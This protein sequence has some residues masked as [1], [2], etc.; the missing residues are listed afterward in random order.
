MLNNKLRE[1]F[2]KN[3]YF[4]IK[5]FP[6]KITDQF[7][8]E[9]AKSIKLIFEREFKKNT[10]FKLN[11]KDWLINQGMAYLEKI[12][13]KYLVEIYNQIP[14]SHIFYNLINYQKNIS[15]I[16]ELLNRPKK[17]NIYIHPATLRMDV[18]INYKYMYGWHRDNNS[19]MPGSNFIQLWFPIVNNI[20]KNLG[21]IHVLKG[22]HIAN[23]GKG[24]TTTSTRSELSRLKADLPIR[25]KLNTKVVDKNK[26]EEKYIT[27]KVGE[28]VFFDSAL[29]HKGGL[30][31]TKNM[32]RYVVAAFCHDTTNKKWKFSHKYYKK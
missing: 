6:K 1:K 8:S 18:P 11:N 23:N 10:K 20:A 31:K 28:V 29:M 12:N 13:H 16:N 3:G 15:I 5:I 2:L 14:S 30:N 9:L 25:P 19:N 17:N 21:G 4:K 24:L 27:A 32:M 26:Y 7:K 22:S